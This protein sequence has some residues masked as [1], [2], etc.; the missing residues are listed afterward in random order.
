[1][2]SRLSAESLFVV[3]RSV[4]R[5]MREYGVCSYPLNCFR[6]LYT[7][8]EKNLIRLDIIETQKLSAAFEAAAEYF[9]SVDSYV[10]VMKPVPEHWKDR[11]PDRRCNFTLAHELGHIFCG[12]LAIPFE[13]KSPEERLRDDLEADEFAGCLLM[14]AGLVSACRPKDRAALAASFLVSEQAAARRLQN[15]GSPEIFRLFPGYTCPRCG[16]VSAPGAAFCAACGMENGPA[17]GILPIPYPAV[18]AG[19]TGRVMICPACRN[20][21]FSE[22]ARFC[23]I[24]GTPA[25]NTCADESCGRA[26]SPGARFCAACGSETVYARRGL[27]PGWKEVREAYIRRQLGKEEGE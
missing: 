5:F 10:I 19:E 7:I 3:G 2:N 1:M 20:E 14:P 8:R 23:R 18:P 4:R 9:P 27:L 16:F 17:A 25:C 22:N 24:C 11:S 15:L 6:L 26:C 21:E 13:A 12:H